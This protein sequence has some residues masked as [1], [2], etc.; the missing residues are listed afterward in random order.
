MVEKENPQSDG[1][2]QVIHEYRLAMADF[3]SSMKMREDLS[4][5]IG[6][7]TTQ[8]IR[9]TMIAMTILGLAMFYLIHT[10]TSDMLHITQHM[11]E[12]SGYMKDMSLN[13]RAVATSVEE[14]K[15]S[16][17]RMNVFMEAIPTM[18]TSVAQMS[19]DINKMTGDMK[20]MNDNMTTMSF[21]MANMSMQFVRVN[22]KLGS[23]GYDVNRMSSPMRFFPF[24]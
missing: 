24:Q 2:A 3:N 16:V 4:L 13:F 8:I 7:R 6:R 10:L 1:M 9:F 17:D 22:G 12:M 18:N 21:D 19:T 5:R 11:D 14:M 20:K 15:L 23:M